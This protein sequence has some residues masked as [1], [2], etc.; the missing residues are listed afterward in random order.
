[1]G[2]GCAEGQYRDALVGCMDCLGTCQKSLVISRCRSF[3]EAVNCKTQPGHYYD[4]LLNKC[5]KCKEICGTHPPEC[6]PHC[7]TEVVAGPS[8]LKDSDILIYSLLAVCL[9]LLFSSLFLAFVAFL[10]GGKAKT[11]NPGSTQGS[12]SKKEKE[13]EARP[14]QETGIPARQLGKSSKDILTSLSCPVNLEPSDDSLPTETCVCVHC[15]P[16]MNVRGPAHSRT[17]RDPPVLYQQ[18]VLQRAQTQNGGACWT[19][20]SFRTYDMKVQEEAAVG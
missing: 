14:G 3:C 16:D 12:Q 4:K 9:A 18:A 10:R 2:G 1:M 6:A 5:I 19:E 13:S 11:S 20:Q 8:T 7:Q 15:F 17:L